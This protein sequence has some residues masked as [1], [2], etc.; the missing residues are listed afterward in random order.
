MSTHP[1]QTDNE[2]PAPIRN[3][4]SASIHDNAS[5]SHRR[6]NSSAA[7]PATIAS[8][9]NA[10]ETPD[11]IRSSFLSTVYDGAVSHIQQRYPHIGTLYFTKIFRGTLFP[12]G[13]V[14]LDV[15]RQDTSPPDHE[16]L[17]HLLYCFEIYGQIVCMFADP[18]GGRKEAELQRAL[19]DYRA[20]LLKH[21]KWAT[22]ESLREWHARVLEVMMREG[23]DRPAGWRQRWSEFDGVLRRMR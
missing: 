10:T 17:P 2:P 6:S 1:V 16:S 12:P 19:S 18:Q 20:R 11:T 8:T 9:I 22:F 13:L 4:P 3:D 14:W 15:D 7:D 5:S 21:S 23:Q